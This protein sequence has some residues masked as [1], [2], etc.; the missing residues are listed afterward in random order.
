[1]GAISLQLRME[2]VR[3]PPS[4]YPH[5]VGADE[6]AG[7]RWR[8]SPLYGVFLIIVTALL[9]RKFSSHALAPVLAGTVSFLLGTESAEQLPSP[10]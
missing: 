1:M 9:R 7:L 2:F 10:L 8:S 4:P 3:R 5:N 6:S